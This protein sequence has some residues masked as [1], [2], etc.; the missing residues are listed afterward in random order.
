M[1][2]AS[3]GLDACGLRIS[4]L[5]DVDRDLN[6]SGAPRREIGSDVARIGLTAAVR[7]SRR[8]QIGSAI[9]LP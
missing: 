7:R 4:N 2:M 5:G 8:L 9:A 1:P 3:F 6:T